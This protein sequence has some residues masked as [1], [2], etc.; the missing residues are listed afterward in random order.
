MSK[1]LFKVRKRYSRISNTRISSVSIAGFEKEFNHRAV[2]CCCWLWTGICLLRFNFKN[3][4]LYSNILGELT[5]F[6]NGRKH[7]ESRRLV[8]TQ[9]V[10]NVFPA[11]YNGKLVL[12]Q[13]SDD[14]SVPWGI[15]DSYRAF[16]GSITHFMLWEYAL[17]LNDIKKAYIRKPMVNKAIVTWDQFKTRARG[18]TVRLKRFSTAR[19][20]NA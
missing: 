12:G 9:A 8:Q 4:C 15:R 2:F 18:R 13:D 20:N 3:N 14:F 7:G 5:I 10:T 16:Q 11:S 19:R 1:Y 6:R 17:S